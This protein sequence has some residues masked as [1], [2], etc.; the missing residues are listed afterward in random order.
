MTTRYRVYKSRTIPRW[1]ALNLDPER[2]DMHVFFTWRQ[3][4]DYADLKAR[5]PVIGRFGLFWLGIA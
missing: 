2:F 4:Q 1:V 3:A 5:E